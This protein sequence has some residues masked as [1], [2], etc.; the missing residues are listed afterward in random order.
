MATG[1][2]PVDELA[3]VVAPRRLLA[4]EG[5]GT[6]LVVAGGCILALVIAGWLAA[7]LLTSWGPTQIDPAATL[8]PPGGAHLVGTD[9]NGMDVW[10]RTLHAVPVDLGI[11]VLSVAVAAAVGSAIGVAIGFVGGWIDDA[12]M[13]VADILQAF[14]TFILAL[15]VAA[16]IG[17]SPLDLICV[18]AVVYAPSYAR[19]ARA[20]ARTVRELPYVDAAR[21]TGTGVGGI[22]RRHVLPNCLA[23]VRVLA[24]LNCGW[25]MLALAG[26]SFV[27]LGIAP[28]HAEWGAMISLGS[29]DVVSGR[30][31]TSVP[32]GVALLL[33]VLAF[34]MIGEGLQ[35]RSVRRSL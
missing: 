22:L 14:P 25:A 10:S 16:L 9:I 6:G 35:D 31:W 11:A 30:W 1:A 26:L 24:P 15:A 18:L 32:P 27:G 5:S 3:R 13:R 19:L 33:C 28:P 4:R 8:S 7:H 2:A 34:S 23:P 21:L 29:S 12:L 20:E 17:R